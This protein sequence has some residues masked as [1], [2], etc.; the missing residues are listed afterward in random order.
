M[1]RKCDEDSYGDL[2]ELLKS[3]LLKSVKTRIMAASR[4]DFEQKI[5]RPKQIDGETWREKLFRNLS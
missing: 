3:D 2:K 4:K 1:H 5:I